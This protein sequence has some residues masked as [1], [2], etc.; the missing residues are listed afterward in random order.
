MN[1]LTYGPF[2]FHNTSQ[3]AIRK[4]FVEINEVDKGLECAVG[5]YIFATRGA[6]NT[7]IPLYVGKTDNGFGERIRHHFDVNKFDESLK[8][9]KNLSLFL[10]AQA[11]PSGRLKKATKRTPPGRGLKSID[12][13]EF[14]L[15]GSCLTKNR[16][17]LNIKDSTFHTSMRVPGYWNS[18]IEDQNE[19]AKK[20]AKMLKGVQ[21]SF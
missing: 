5:V 9:M 13:L 16:D 10:I 11:T 2:E 17:L 15:I 19:S 1:F 8:V 3:A 7:F 21:L 12:R 4:A 6:K 18:A 20:L 14:A